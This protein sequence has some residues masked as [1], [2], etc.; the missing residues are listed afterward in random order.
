VNYSC[1]A[2]LVNVHWGNVTVQP[3]GSGFV[4][5]PAVGVPG[6]LSKNGVEKFFVY[7]MIFVKEITL[8]LL[9]FA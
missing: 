1:F 3:E 6:N 5:V 9:V 4:A 8:L 2:A 7:A